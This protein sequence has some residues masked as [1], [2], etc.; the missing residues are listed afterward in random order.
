MGC[1][2][3]VRSI[4][5]DNSTSEFKGVLEHQLKDNKIAEQ[6]IFNGGIGMPRA[7][8]ETRT[9]ALPTRQAAALVIMTMR[10]LGLENTGPNLTAVTDV[11]SH[12]LTNTPIY[13]DLSQ[14]QAADLQRSFAGTD[15][16]SIAATRERALIR[17]FKRVEPTTPVCSNCGD[18]PLSERGGAVRSLEP[19]SACPQCQRGRFQIV[20]MIIG[21]LSWVTGQIMEASIVTDYRTERGAMIPITDK[22]LRAWVPRISSTLEDQCFSTGVSLYGVLAVMNLKRGAF[23]RPDEAEWFLENPQQYHVATPEDFERLAL[24]AKLFLDE[25]EVTNLPYR[26]YLPD[27]SARTDYWPIQIGERTYLVEGQIGSGAKCDVFRARWDN[28]PTELVV[29]KLLVSPD[30]ED[31]MRR[32]VQNMRLLDRSDERGSEIMKGRVPALVA[33]GSAK[34]PSGATFPAVVYRYLHGMDWTLSDVM[35]AYPNGV[36][37]RTLVWMCNRLL[38]QMSWWHDTGLIHGAILPEHLIIHPRDHL[39]NVIGWDAALRRNQVQGIV[40]NGRK[41][42]YPPEVISQKPVSHQT[43]IAMVCRTMIAVAGGDPATGAGI[44]SRIDRRIAELLTMHAHYDG[45]P[46]PRRISA[47]DLYEQVKAVAR[48]VFGPP[49]YHRFFMWPTPAQR[50]AEERS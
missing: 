26:Q 6:S 29:I 13:G 47:M 3:C 32:E 22:R 43:D 45:N 15:L 28:N 8:I 17:L 31:L 33:H 5:W 42:F 20:P 24:E 21:R 49:S 23:K 10:T 25:R 14:I 48:S 18:L 44:P 2:A 34:L 27:G 37:G 4:P 11:L 30:D 39:M 36:S 9:L 38:L 16:D 40:M 50:V 35:E 7:P 19:G 1:C 46:M 41:S 12:L